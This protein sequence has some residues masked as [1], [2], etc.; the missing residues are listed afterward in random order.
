MCPY[1]L[2]MTLV[3]Q[4]PTTPC[5]FDMWKNAHIPRS[6]VHPP[7]NQTQCSYRALLHHVSLTCG[8]CRHTQV[9]CTSPTNQTQWSYRVLLHHVSLTY[10]SMQTYPCEIYLPPIDPSGTEPYY[11]MSLCHVEA[12]RHTQVR[13]ILLL[14]TPSATD[15]SYT[16]SV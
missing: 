13:C 10:G 3:V 5:L 16:V 1:P 4:S 11:S 9:R 14:I 8:I 12:C 15:P 6:D 2:L 7:T